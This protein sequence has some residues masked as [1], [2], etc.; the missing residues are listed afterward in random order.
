MRCPCDVIEGSLVHDVSSFFGIFL[1]S[2]YTGTWELFSAI[3]MVVLYKTQQ[4]IPYI[5]RKDLSQFRSKSQKS[6]DEEVWEMGL[7]IEIKKYHESVHKRIPFHSLN[8][9]LI[10]FQRL[11]YNKNFG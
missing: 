5:E 1:F 3:Y 11:Y 6:M 7:E 2:P 10:Y 8:F 4:T 9:F